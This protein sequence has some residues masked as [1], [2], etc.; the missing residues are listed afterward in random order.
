MTKFLLGIL[1]GILLTFFMAVFVVALI[2]SLSPG[3]PSIQKDSI[4]TMRLRG[5]I[6]EHAASEFSIQ[7]LRHGPPPTLLDLRNAL[8]EAADDER[9]SALVL[10][11]GGLGTGWAKAQEIRYGI[12]N[13]KKSG[14]PVIALLNNA[15]TI[16][17][18]VSSSADEI[19]MVPEAILDM[20]G[21]RA[22]VSFYADTLE[23]LGI[24]AEV[25]RI[26]K[27]K[28]AAEPFSR[29][30]MSD[31]YREVVN[32]VLDDLYTRFIATVA[33]SREK[34]DDAFRALLDEGP[35]L[36]SD[37]VEA[38]L[39]DGLK[40]EDQF[41]DYVKEKLEQ[42][43][44]REV[45]FSAYRKPFE[46]A[47]SFGGGDQIAVVYAVG[48][49]M[50]GNSEVDP[51]LDA[52]ILGDESFA[53]T[54]REVREKDDVKAVILRVN[55]PGGDAFASDRMWREVNLLRE[56]KPL[57]VSMSNVAASGGYYISMAQA[58]VV[59]YPGT[60][61]GSIGVIYGKMNLRGLYDKIGVKKEILT[62]GRFA[63]IDSDYRP[64][65]REER[66]KLRHE[67]QAVYKTFVQKVADSRERSWDEIEEVAQGRVWLGNQAY[68]K[69]LVDELGGFDRAIELAQQAAELQDGE[70]RLVPYP[71][72]QQ[73]IEALFDVDRFAWKG[74]LR[75]P[76]NLNPKRFAISPSLLEG[77]VLRLAPY[78]ITVQ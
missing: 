51:F 63:A 15:G 32:S 30:S 57:V 76:S 24:E 53:K 52:R 1:T 6:P 50:S 39:I 64:L 14:K 11:S 75:L 73:L 35:F 65:T 48:D 36:S 21:L 67:I 8:K 37:A 70:Y 61:T 62:R 56:K 40:Y 12:E 17:Y 5:D 47:T 13:F 78:T 77:G 41:R 9:I 59:A 46:S 19:Y 43:E 38:G 60:F 10:E 4:L 44:W 25:E 20:K 71:A 34:P 49:I 3:Q 33:K 26:G 69:G 18:F 42:E 23:K 28:S 29:S 74:S 31:E 66:A 2:A 68:E 55:S 72:P 58:P 54:L 16:D 7:W 22:E 45:T 27:Y